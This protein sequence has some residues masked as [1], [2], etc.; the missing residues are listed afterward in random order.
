MLKVP[1]HGSRT[2]MTEKFLDI[3]RPDVAII[4]VGKNNYGHP[5]AEILSKLAIKHTQVL[6]TDTD[7]DIEIVSDG[8]GYTV[9][10]RR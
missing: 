9:K 4:S 7:G 1:H 3:V 2:G 5:S 10:K 8:K 6:R